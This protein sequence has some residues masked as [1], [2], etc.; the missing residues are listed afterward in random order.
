[1]HQEN[2]WNNTKDK[3]GHFNLFINYFLHAMITETVTLCFQFIEA[4]MISQSNIDFELQEINTDKVK[5]PTSVINRF[6]GTS[7]IKVR[8]CI[9]MTLSVTVNKKD[10]YFMLIFE[11]L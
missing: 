1:M 11:L 10:I 2:K 4:F 5:T 3:G 6:D 9:I 8:K 7:K